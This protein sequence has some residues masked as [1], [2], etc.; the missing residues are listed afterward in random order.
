MKFCARRQRDERSNGSAKSLLC[1]SLKKSKRYMYIRRVLA[2]KSKYCISKQLP[3]C[4]TETYT[5][6]KTILRFPL[7]LQR[8]RIPPPTGVFLSS[9]LPPRSADV[10]SSRCSSLLD[11]TLLSLGGRNTGSSA[12]S[13]GRSPCNTTAA[14]DAWKENRN[15]RL[16]KCVKLRR[17]R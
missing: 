9:S 2:C 3:H 1:F 12:S 7:K 17:N 13:G 11:L 4:R 14:D 8:S 15:D 5:F 10:T 6:L 16:K